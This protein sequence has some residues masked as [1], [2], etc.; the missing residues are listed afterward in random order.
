VR[1]KEIS[2]NS[3]DNRGHEKDNLSSVYE[4]HAAYSRF[5]SQCP[6]IAEMGRTDGASLRYGLVSSTEGTWGY[7][8]FQT[9]FL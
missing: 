7:G 5:H 8:A 2:D 9:T 1:S 4:D 3:G 6:P